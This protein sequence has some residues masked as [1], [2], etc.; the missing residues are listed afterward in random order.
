MEK[1]FQREAELTAKTINELKGDGCFAFT[2]LADNHINPTREDEIEKY[3]HTIENIQDVHKMADIDALFY[4]G[5]MTYINSVMH[6]DYWTQERFYEVEKSLKNDLLACNPNTYFI[7]GNHDGVNA[8]PADPKNWFDEMISFHGDKV[9]SIKDEGYYFVDFP[10]YRTR[11]ICLMD[12]LTEDGKAFF[13]YKPKQLKWLAETALYI[14]ENYKVLIFAHITLHTGKS[15]VE[16]VNLK[17]L[18]GILTAFQNKTVYSGEII[19]A[20]FTKR[21]NG[22][23]SAMFGG[24]DHVQ[25]SG[26]GYGMPFRLIETPCNLIH[27]PHTEKD[28]GCPE[29]FVAADRER[30]TV[31]EDLWDTV[32]FDVKNNLIHIVR[33]GSGEDVTYEL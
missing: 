3:K 21:N 26:F 31:T 7:A 22:E 13:G 6:G 14:P 11:A 5:D 24:H 28:W 29:G 16:I 19:K 18:A 27:L 4:L 23:I 30:G 17:E 15:S 25:W 2:L 12:T 32:V 8:K 20:N 10:K 33:F 9:N 1:H